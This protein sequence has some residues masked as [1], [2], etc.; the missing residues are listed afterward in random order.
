MITTFLPVHRPSIGISLRASTLSLVGL[1]RRAF[2]REV[3]VCADKRALASGMLT[4]AASGSNIADG[5]S[6]GTELRALMGHRRDRA[7]AISLPDEIATIRLFS[8]ETLPTQ[9]AERDAIIRWRFQ[10]EAHVQAGDER[11]L[12]RTYQGE[13]S[14]SVLAAVLDE[15]VFAQYVSVLVAADLLAVSIGFETLQLFDVFRGAMPPVSESFFV[16]HTDG[17]LTCIALRD[18]R[19]LFMRRRGVTDAVEHVREELIGTLQYFYDQFPRLNGSKSSRSPLYFV[20]TGGGGELARN[21]VR[22]RELMA[23]PAL[24]DAREI[25]MIPCDWSMSSL[26]IKTPGLSGSFLPAAACCVGKA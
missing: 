5:E 14:V 10:Q 21:L 2:C 22:E 17:T 1:R 8:F 18:G 24:A 13:S 23:I 9:P 4:P 19:P 3:V 15:A 25:E 16:H 11:L 26:R 12:Y 7:V 6:L 20:E